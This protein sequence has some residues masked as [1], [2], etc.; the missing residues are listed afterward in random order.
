MYRQR[1]APSLIHLQ[2]HVKGAVPTS[3]IVLLPE[4][5]TLLKMKDF[6]TAFDRTY[7][8][9]ADSKR[10]FRRFMMVRCVAE[11]YPLSY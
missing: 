9:I 10:S 6:C 1:S 7:T 5:N 2:L 4:R 8:F 3:S 11:K